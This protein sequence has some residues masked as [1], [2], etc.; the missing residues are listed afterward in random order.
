MNV[1]TEYD[2]N[3]SVIPNGSEKYVALTINK[4]LVFI[5]SKQ[6]LNSSLKKLFRNLSDNV[7]KYLSKEFNLE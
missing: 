4:N 2:V 3:V 5:D 6:F 7:F 1:I